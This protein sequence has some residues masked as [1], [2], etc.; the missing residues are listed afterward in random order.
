MRPDP[1]TRWKIRLRAVRACDRSSRISPVIFR[2]SPAQV[3]PRC[4]SHTFFFQAPCPKY[5]FPYGN[6]K[7]LFI[8]VKAFFCFPCPAEVLLFMLFHGYRVPSTG[9]FPAID[10][11]NKSDSVGAGFFSTCEKC[12]PFFVTAPLFSCKDHS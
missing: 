6:V 8:S 2:R 10:A 11:A 4:P 3:A 12:P 1:G 5:L 7:R 9:S